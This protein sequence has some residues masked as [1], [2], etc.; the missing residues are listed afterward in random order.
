MVCIE[1]KNEITKRKRKESV[2]SKKVVKV[3]KHSKDSLY[4]LNDR[5]IVYSGFTKY[6]NYMVDQESISAYMR[7]ILVDW[8]NEVCSAFR[9]KRET[10]HYAIHYLDRYLEKVNCYFK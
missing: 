9:L 3:F 8:M 2:L 5:E 7:A 1:L 6:A 4:Y 10:F